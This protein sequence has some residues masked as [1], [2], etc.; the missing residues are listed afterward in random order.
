VTYFGCHLLNIIKNELPTIFVSLWIFEVSSTYRCVTCL[1]LH[2]IWTKFWNV[3]H[4][5]LILFSPTL[6]L[7]LTC[8]HKHEIISFYNTLTTIWSLGSTYLQIN[9]QDAY[10]LRFGRSSYAWKDKE[11]RFPTQPVRWSTKIGVMCNQPALHDV[12]PFLGHIDSGKN[13]KNV[14]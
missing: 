3:T 1:A 4:L 5:I 2:K 14:G 8:T 9:A 13:N 11:I 12:S 6:V 7:A 10:D